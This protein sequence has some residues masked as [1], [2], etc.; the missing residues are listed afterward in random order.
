ALLTSLLEGSLGADDTLRKQIMARTGG[1]PY[2]LVSCAEALRVS[3][4]EGRPVQDVPWNVAQSI[5]QRVAALPPD[6]RELLGVAAVVGQEAP[7]ALLLTLAAQPQAET[8]A[9]L[10]ALDRARL[11]V[12]GTEARYQ[13]P[14]DLI[15][16]VVLSELS[17]VR[18]AGLHQLV[19]AALEQMPEGR[20][21]G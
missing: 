16:E 4:Q 10:E 17:A 6:L 3:A 18:R 15:R 7:G 20:R 12:E 13:F 21:E 1:V 5:G 19:A 8:V 2:F 9:A 14:H 11:L